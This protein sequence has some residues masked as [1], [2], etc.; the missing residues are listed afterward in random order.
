MTE[1][2]FDRDRFRR[3]FE[4]GLPSGDDGYVEEVVNDGGYD[5]ELKKLMYEQF[6]SL[7]IEEDVEENER[8][9][10]IL[11]TINFNINKEKESKFYRI[12]HKFV[13]WSL[14]I[15]A[16]LSL[17]LLIYS[18]LNYY[19]HKF[20]EKEVW[21][22]IKA[23]AWTRVQF[24][25]PDGTTGWL[26]SNSNVKYLGNFL[27]ERQVELTGEAFFN[28]VK[29]A[30]RPFTVATSDIQLEVLGT[31][32]NV[33]SY[34]D[35]DNIEVVLE[36]GS[37]KFVNLRK[38]QSQIMKPNELIVY[39]KQSESFFSEVVQPKKYLSWTEGNLVFRNDPI[40]VVARRLARW[41]NTDVVLKNNIDTNLR[42]RA[43]FVGES[44]E[45]VLNLLEL[46]L[47]VKC[48]IENASIQSDST[49]SR[50]KII[51]SASKK[52][53]IKHIMPM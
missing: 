14:R 46:S 27:R 49:Y 33:A 51:L 28:V 16:M 30:S 32:F 9:D 10:G 17:P 38:N 11:H 20:V 40:D 7:E 53:G 42:L 29:D 23:P 25:L 18:G 45:E 35:E 50:K 48:T 1:K 44:L 12:R 39:N 34:C 3:F 19:E 26:N 31:K 37:L 2:R 41:F 13:L 21:V 43:T 22:E 6:D 24:R 8:L 52:T 15:A 47:P 4:T 5:R 36:E